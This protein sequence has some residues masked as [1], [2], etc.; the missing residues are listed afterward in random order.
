[1]PPSPA[2]TREPAVDGSRL[3]FIVMPIVIM[4]A[5]AVL[6]ALPFLGARDQRRSASKGQD[7]PLAGGACQLT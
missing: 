1:M 7:R 4:A 5:L 6:V 2:A 3:T